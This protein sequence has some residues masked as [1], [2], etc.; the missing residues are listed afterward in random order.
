MTTTL[1]RIQAFLTAN[2]LSS[3]PGGDGEAIIVPMALTHC[4]CDVVIHHD[5]D[6]KMLALMGLVPITVPSERRAAVAE[7]L[8]RLN[9]N[10]TGNH[11]LMDFNDGDVRVRRDVDGTHPPDLELLLGNWFYSLCLALDGF[12]PALMSVVSRGA[13]PVQAL[14]QGEADYM[15][16]VDGRAKQQR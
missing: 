8:T 10:L 7:F 3:H 13:N 16:V 11:F 5:R 4:R 1:E 15:A 14:E 6:T 12:F 9:W 2:E